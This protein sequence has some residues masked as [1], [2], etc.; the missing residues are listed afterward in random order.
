MDEGT[1][2]VRPITLRR[3]VSDGLLARGYKHVGH[4]YHVKAL[5]GEFS[6][7]V[8]TGPPGGRGD[9]WPSVGLRH[10]AV[11]HLRPKLMELPA[12]RHSSTVA[13]NVGEILNG[14][15][16]GWHDPAAATDA[17]DA[18]DRA[19]WA[20][21]Q[22]A[23]LERLPKAWGLRP[24]LAHDLYTL[25]PVYLLLGDQRHVRQLLGEGERGFCQ[26]EN[27]I[28]AQFRAFARNVGE[29]LAN[30]KPA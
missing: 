5:A 6:S 7:I 10:E 19:V 4:G 30:H 27:Q 28:C 29:F 12:Y 1:D 26:E 2:P 16:R 8:D 14:R 21:N 13:A 25:V 24:G 22:F 17:M 11:E 15:H 20:M 23:T 18:I 9:I 3:L